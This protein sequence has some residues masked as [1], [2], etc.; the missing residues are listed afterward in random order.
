MILLPNHYL[1]KDLEVHIYFYTLG[2]G[3][4]DLSFNMDLA[5][6]SKLGKLE[7]SFNTPEILGPKRKRRVQFDCTLQPS[8]IDA[9]C[10][11]EESLLPKIK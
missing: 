5:E 8:S 4:D 10:Q 7:S 11:T 6:Q 1:I 2:F 3:K 9:E